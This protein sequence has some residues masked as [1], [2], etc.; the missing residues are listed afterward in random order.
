MTTMIMMMIRPS[1]IITSI[2]IKLTDIYFHI[3]SKQ[4][5]K[6]CR[7]KT[8][9]WHQMGFF[10][11]FTKTRQ[12]EKKKKK[13]ENEIERKT[14][15]WKCLSF[16]SEL[17]KFNSFTQIILCPSKSVVFTMDEKR[18]RQNSF[19]FKIIEWI[20]SQ[21]KIDWNCNWWET[22][23]TWAKRRA[24]RGSGRGCE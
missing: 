6:R 9:V 10:V 16:Y 5:T 22:V 11:R 12:N 4:L 14:E 2:R 18:R 13:L 1:I 8:I 24:R 17:I 21:A 20:F 7:S 15:K 3:L 23:M 19:K